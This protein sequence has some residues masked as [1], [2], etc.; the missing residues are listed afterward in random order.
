MPDREVEE[1]TTARI[2]ALKV[3]SLTCFSRPWY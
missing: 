1:T 2:P 3:F